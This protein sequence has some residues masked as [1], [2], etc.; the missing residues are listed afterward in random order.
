MADYA[1]DVLVSALLHH[2]IADV[3][4]D[5]NATVV[6]VYTGVGEVCVRIDPSIMVIPG[7]AFFV[8]T[9]PYSMLG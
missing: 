6:F 1:V 3:M 4:A 7:H 2:Q 9:V 5:D 8:T